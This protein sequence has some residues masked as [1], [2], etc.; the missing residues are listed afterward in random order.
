MANNLSASFPEVRAGEMQR[1]FFKKNIA[2]V[3][4]NF[5]TWL[6][7][8]SYGDTLNRVYSSMPEY[9][10]AYT[11][12]T[13]IPEVDLTDTKESLVINKQYAYRFY[14]DDFDNI[15]D[16]YSVA[17]EY[18][19]KTWE[20][21][22]NQVDA[23]VLA[24]ALNAGSTVDGWT[25]AV[26]TVMPTLW[27]VNQAFAKKNI[28][29]R[30]RYWVISPEFENYLVQYAA[31]R[32]TVQWDKIGLN[33][34]TMTYMGIDFY[35]SNLLCGSAELALATK[36]TANDTVTIAWVTFTFVSTIGTTPG[37][38]LIGA[39]A[40]AT[41]ANLAALINAP[42]TTT[43]KGVALSDADAKFFASRISATNDDAADKLTV[44]A[45]WVWTLTVDSSLT[46]GTDWWTATAQ[47][48]HNLFGVKGN[49]YLIMQRQPSVT[50]VEAQD[51]MWKYFKNAVLY[52]VKTFH[53]NA[54]AMVD[55]TIRSDAFTA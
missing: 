27:N 50:E 33:G 53:D 26:N 18:W 34:Y 1:E 32:Q 25:M 28:M 44:V 2:K 46:A 40:D 55:V 8:K 10:D 11:R 5:Q 41:R 6:D 45:K 49:P 3:I 14:I 47:L 54:Q 31:W 39:D 42:A 20:Y 23:D 9:P 19:K 51:K 21:L 13:T 36:P 38:V 52:G 4:C 48:Q 43:T 37:N 29:S 30:D 15:Q 22:S 17:I 7:G 35:T 12:G 24:E 16:K